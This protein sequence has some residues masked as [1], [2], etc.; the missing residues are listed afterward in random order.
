MTGQAAA[1]PPAPERVPY[2]LLDRAEAARRWTLAGAGVLLAAVAAAFLGSDLRWVLSLG[3]A[4]AG[5][6]IGVGVYLM[7]Y[8]TRPPRELRPF[9]TGPLTCVFGGTAL[10]P[11]ARAH[12]AI[13]SSSLLPDP[14]RARADR[15]WRVCRFGALTT[16]AA[17][18]VLFGAVA[19]ALLYVERESREASPD[20]WY[21]MAPVVTAIFG[22]FLV[23]AFNGAV[24]LICGLMTPVDPD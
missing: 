10:G 12:C 16:S 17:S 15:A 11:V 21:F 22:G 8:L 6:V 1:L 5:W 7:T 18:L 24:A 23:V 9:G 2:E 14:V 4:L 13:A 3:L 20:A 19:I